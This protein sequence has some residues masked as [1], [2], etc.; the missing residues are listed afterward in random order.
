MMVAPAFCFPDRCL[1]NTDQENFWN[2]KEVLSLPFR[3]K[4]GDRLF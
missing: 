3:K 1:G 2:K 4:G